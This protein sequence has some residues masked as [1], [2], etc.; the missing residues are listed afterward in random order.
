MKALFLSA[1]IGLAAFSAR[2][3]PTLNVTFTQSN[4]GID[5]FQFTALDPGVHIVSQYMNG[6]LLVVGPSFGFNGTFNFADF[7][8]IGINQPS[9]IVDGIEYFGDAFEV[10][11]P[12]GPTPTIPD[13]G[14]TALLL[15]LG[16][17]GLAVTHKL[18]TRRSATFQH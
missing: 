3:I 7:L 16:L 13:A 14:E 15:L 2:A 1:I 9:T 18:L 10:V 17:G 5:Y 12:T 11:Q 6:Q 8:Q 4:W